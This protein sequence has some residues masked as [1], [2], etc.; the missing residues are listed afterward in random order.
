MLGRPESTLRGYRDRFREF[1]PTMGRGRSRRHPEAAVE[2][3]RFIGEL[4]ESGLLDSQVLEKLE[5]KYTRTLDVT[6]HT[7]KS[8]AEQLGEARGQLS[9]MAHELEA[10]TGRLAAIERAQDE[11]ARVMDE[12]RRQLA[13][14]A[15]QAA[16]QANDFEEKLSRARVRMDELREDLDRPPWWAFWRKRKEPSTLGAPGKK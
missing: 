2:V 8:L 11:Q 7:R 14:Q 12:L 4:K 3:F 6:T 9:F 10:A 5:E 16:E 15:E 1:I 13:G